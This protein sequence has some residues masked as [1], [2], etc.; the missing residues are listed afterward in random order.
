MTIR[1]YANR[2]KLALDN[3]EITLS[4]SRIH[5]DDCEECE[6]QEGYIDTIEKIIRLDGDLSEEERLRLLEIADRCPVHKSLK[7]E[8]RMQSK[9]HV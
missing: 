5:A 6:Q 1:M 4:H 3:I 8:I 2:K 9:L 7:N